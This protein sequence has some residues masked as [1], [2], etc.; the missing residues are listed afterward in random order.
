MKK[1]GIEDKNI[2]VF[3][4]MMIRKM[5][6]MTL[7]L[8]QPWLN[9][10]CAA[11]PENLNGRAYSGWNSLML[12]MLQ[13]E[14]K[15]TTPVYMTFKQAADEGV[16]VKKGE[17]SFPVHFWNFSV[18]DKESGEKISI[19]DY[20]KLSDSEKER[21][22]VIPYMKYFNVFNVEQTT[23]PEVKPERWEKIKDKFSIGK[24]IDNGGKAVCPELDYMLENKTWVCPINVMKSNDAFYSVSKDTITVPLKEQYKD[25]EEFYSTLLHE[26]AHSTGA[27]NRL[28]RKIHNTFGDKDYAREELVAELTA[29]LSLNV[30][31]LTSTIQDS[32]VAYLQ[33]WIDTLKEQPQFIMTILGDV[34]KAA[35]MIQE[36]VCN[37]EVKEKIKDNTIKDIGDFIEKRNEENAKRIPSYSE[38]E[39]FSVKEAVARKTTGNNTD[40]TDRLSYDTLR[41]RFPDAVLLFRNTASNIYEVFNEDAVKCAE[42]LG[43]VRTNRDFGKER[44]IPYASFPAEKLDTFLPKLVRAG[45]RV[46][47]CDM[48][49]AELKKEETADKKLHSTYLG[50]GISFWE[51][52]DLEYKGHISDD[53]KVT[54]YAEFTPRNKE[55]IEEI[56]RTGN[57][58]IDNG[59]LALE[60]LNVPSKINVNPVTGEEQRFSVETIDGKEYVCSGKSV[61]SD[62]P[63]KFMDISE[64]EN[65]RIMA[66]KQDE[67]QAEPVKET[68]NQRHSYMMLGRLVEDCKYY[69]DQ[70]GSEE[71]LWAKNVEEQIQ[72]MRGFYHSVDEKPQW[73][74]EEQLEDYASRMLQEKAER[75]AAKHQK[76]DISNSKTDMDMEEKNEQKKE[77]KDGINVY[78]M[79][80]GKYGVY[81]VENG[82]RSKTRQMSDED[83][84]QYFEGLKGQ[85]ID[86]VNK[87]R[88]KL[89]SLYFPKPLPKI[90][91][92]V[93]ERI[94]DTSVYKMQDGKTYAVRCKID[95]TQMTGTRVRPEHTR[96]FFEGFK[97]MSVEEKEMRKAELAA[98][99]FKNELNGQQQ[100]VKKGISR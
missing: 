26:M 96:A 53:R 12:L 51:E 68:G 41:K 87:R 35:N 85:G 36:T 22:K 63:E 30:M 84:K 31:G 74:T 4:E 17:T 39:H 71:Q 79:D 66:D 88:E 14:K 80:N 52:G 11:L 18:K 62:E 34:S 72:T 8:K 97:E 28:D 45:E 60:P 9:S 3:A 1:S 16:S 27:E 67:K 5:E 99:Y 82:V 56:A 20:R 32:N 23:L 54:L 78:K 73:L 70:H 59:S 95:G 2:T 42:L 57:L 90:T 48:P 49:P 21:Y 76:T 15:Y 69:L 43:I 91:P 92:E 13:E 46:A 47:I 50:N 98:K 77:V 24:L 83:T 61:I 7:D 100:E 40:G 19:D 64:Y 38:L 93:K 6:S 37:E 89:K 44:K 94:T 86:E 33:S 75:E 29:A 58:L 55:R 10:T 81:F 65:N 25:G